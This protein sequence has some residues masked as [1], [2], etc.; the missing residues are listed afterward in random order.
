MGAAKKFDAKITT[1]KEACQSQ[2]F[3]I[4]PR[5]FSVENGELTPTLKLKRGVV[6]DLHL[7]VIDRMYEA[8]DAYVAYSDE[9]ATVAAAEPAAPVEQKE[10]KKEEKTAEEKVEE[11]KKEEKTAEEKK[12]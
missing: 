4:L 10:E 11:E 2:K 5:D 6:N 7:E 1:I 12:D 3:T 8:K 9:Y